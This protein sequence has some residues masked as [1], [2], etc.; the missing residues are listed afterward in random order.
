MADKRERRKVAALARDG[1]GVVVRVNAGYD[2]KRFRRYLAEVEAGNVK[3][4]G[5]CCARDLAALFDVSPTC[6]KRM[7]DDFRARQAQQLPSPS[8][9]PATPSGQGPVHQ[10]MD[11]ANTDFQ[12]VFDQL[13]H[14]AVAGNLAPESMVKKVTD[15]T[16]LATARLQQR[17]G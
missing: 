5:A 17:K 1:N 2:N 6:D 10:R 14:V 11:R 13:L 15:M 9:T 12:A 4:A 3:I 7:V 16:I 8:T